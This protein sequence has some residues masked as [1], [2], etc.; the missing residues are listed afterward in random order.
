MYGEKVHQ[1]I[2]HNKETETGI[3]IHFVNDRYDEGE[4]ILQKKIN[5]EKNDTPETLAGKVHA[6]EYEWY[7]RVIGKILVEN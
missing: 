3:T 7:P 5:I 1:A 6:L 4:I 2:F